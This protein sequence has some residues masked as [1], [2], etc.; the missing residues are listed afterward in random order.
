LKKKEKGDKAQ[1]NK[2]QKMDIDTLVSELEQKQGQKKKN[3]K[4]RK[5]GED[6]IADDEGVVGADDAF[7]KLLQCFNT[8]LEAESTKKV[9]KVK[10][11]VDHNW[12]QRLRQQIQQMDENTT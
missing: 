2:Y 10:P 5:D 11:N 9:N 1:S 6:R 7:E 3:K 4:K 12:L 8:R